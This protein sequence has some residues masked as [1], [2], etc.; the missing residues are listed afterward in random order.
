EFA[1]SGSAVA[2]RQR[3]DVE[4]GIVSTVN[5]G[6]TVAGGFVDVSAATGG[7]FVSVAGSMVLGGSG[8]S[9]LGLSVI[10]NDAERDVLAYVGNDPASSVTA[11]GAIDLDVGAVTVD[12]T[13][14]GVRVDVVGTATAISSKQ[15][16]IGESADDPL[17]G[18]SLP[19]L[20]GEAANG[21]SGIGIAGS[22]GVNVIRDTAEAFIDAHGSIAAASL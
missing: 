17:D 1:F 10:V 20:F 11:T 7:T 12:A 9:G 14:G 15:N 5:G 6:A 3:S 2:L 8:S 16:P 4:A 18:V 22:A 21:K 19:N 13:I